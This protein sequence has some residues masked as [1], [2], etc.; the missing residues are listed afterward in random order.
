MNDEEYAE[1]TR[2][3]IFDGASLLLHLSP[4]KQIPNSFLFYYSSK[5][6]LFV[7]LFSQSHDVA[8]L[9][10]LFQ[11]PDSKSKSI[12]DLFNVLLLGFCIHFDFSFW[13]FSVDEL[14]FAEE[15]E[16]HTKPLEYRRMMINLLPILHDISLH[17]TD[18]NLKVCLSGLIF[19]HLRWPG[20]NFAIYA[21]SLQSKRLWWFGLMECNR[22]MPWRIIYSSNCLHHFFCL[23]YYLF[24]VYRI[25][26]VTVLS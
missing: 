21:S 8:K 7:L 23:I 10:D 12:S 2:H 24:F 25:Q 14:Y 20:V 9:L 1:V 19:W 22:S 6:K 18:N 13:F 11:H 26:Q 15:T 3:K 4:Y 16:T 17:T 5:F